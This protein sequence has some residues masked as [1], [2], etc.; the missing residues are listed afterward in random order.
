MVYFRLLRDDSC[1]VKSVLLSDVVGGI[2]GILDGGR[3]E[4]RDLRGLTDI[5]DDAVGNQ[6]LLVNLLALPQVVGVVRRVGVVLIL[7]I[8]VLTILDYLDWL[9]GPSYHRVLPSAVTFPGVNLDDVNFVHG[10]C[11]LSISV[12]LQG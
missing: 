2:L 6:L 5:T 3:P 8:I 11:E 9:I 10:T 1:S 7:N 4:G 12:D